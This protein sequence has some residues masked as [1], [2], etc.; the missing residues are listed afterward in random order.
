MHVITEN[1]ARN[2]AQRI[3]RGGTFVVP[4]KAILTPMARD[5]LRGRGIELAEDISCATAS[6]TERKRK[7]DASSTAKIKAV[8]TDEAL[9]EAVTQEVSRAL[10]SAKQGPR[11]SP[12]DQADKVLSGYSARESSEEVVTGEN[13]KKG[14]P[15]IVVWGIGGDR[16]GIL[17][18]V[19]EL[20]KKWKIN[21]LEISQTILSGV[22]AM[23]VIVEAGE[24]LS[25]FAEFKAELE[26][27]GKKLGVNLSAQ[28]DD[29]FQFMHRI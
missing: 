10:E 11:T 4:P 26:T 16:P 22:F 25:Q 13:G 21:I 7:R 5:Y 1:E 19:T 9:I 17:A 3:D 15:R 18:D 23:V 2:L 12:T 24:A 20:L 6:E 27:L 29:L 14:G 8:N 28:R